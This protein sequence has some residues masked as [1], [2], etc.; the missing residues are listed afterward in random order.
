MDMLV[1]HISLPF[2]SFI[3]AVSRKGSVKSRYL[4]AQ[5]KGSEFHEDTGW[6][7]KLSDSD[8]RKTR[9]QAIFCWLKQPCNWYVA[10]DVNPEEV[11][12]GNVSLVKRMYNPG[13]LYV[14]SVMN[15]SEYLDK[16]RTHSSDTRFV[17][18]FT[19]E[20]LSEEDMRRFEQ[21]LGERF[22]RLEG[23]IEGMIAQYKPEIM[24]PRLEIP[25]DEI[26]EINPSSWRGRL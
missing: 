26:A 23:V 4:L 17:H 19:A 11:L 6:I 10:F 18:P 2:E 3:R 20:E 9:Y 21:G 22:A 16:I 7:D 13:G 24:V 1:Y 25:K 12:V 5:D 8:I 14:K 15:L